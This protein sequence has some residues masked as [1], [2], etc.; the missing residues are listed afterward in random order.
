MLW[1]AA[2]PRLLLLMRLDNFRELMNWNSGFIK[3]NHMGKNANNMKMP[4]ILYFKF[5]N[6]N[7]TF[8]YITD[9]IYIYYNINLHLLSIIITTYIIK[10]I[11]IQNHYCSSNK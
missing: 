11:T 6:H 1:L 4:I 7:L 5:N 2:I 10:Y 3:I 8:N 9:V